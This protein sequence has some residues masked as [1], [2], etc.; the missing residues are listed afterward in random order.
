MK[1]KLHSSSS[2]MKDIYEKSS[3][4]R[5]VSQYCLEVLIDTYN[6]LFKRKYLR[7]WKGKK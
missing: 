5:C 6:I 1:N 3:Q 7:S 4:E 2:N